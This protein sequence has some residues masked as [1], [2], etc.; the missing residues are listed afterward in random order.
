MMSLV[1]ITKKLKDA[2]T[3]LD[4]DVIHYYAEPGQAAP[5]VVWAE[6]EES[7][8]FYSNNRKKEQVL[9]GY[10]EYYTQQEFDTNTDAIQ[11]ILDNEC[12]TWELNL[13]E[14]LDNEKLIRFIWHWSIRG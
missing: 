10:V 6:T 3:N 11:S 9:G 13:V 1:D 5:Y 12:D 8:P 2:L 4:C 7:E 14:Y